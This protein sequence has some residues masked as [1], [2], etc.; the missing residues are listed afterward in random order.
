MCRSLERATAH[1]LRIPNRGVRPGLRGRASHTAHRAR[2]I[3][4]AHLAVATTSSRP[5]PGIVAPPTARR[6][7]SSAARLHTRPLRCRPGIPANGA[8]WFRW[9]RNPTRPQLHRQKPPSQSGLWPT[10]RKCSRIRF[11]RRGRISRRRHGTKTRRCQLD[12]AQPA[13]AHGRCRRRG[14]RIH[15]SR[16]PCRPRADLS[17][18]LRRFR[19]RRAGSLLVPLDREP[20]LRGSMAALRARPGHRPAEPAQAQAECRHPRP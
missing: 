16:H 2:A 19:G 10:Q 12:P 20:D 1:K 15:L 5:K 6:S 13:R 14:A 4:P 9:L 7:G 3:N 11:A 17:R 18:P 8:C